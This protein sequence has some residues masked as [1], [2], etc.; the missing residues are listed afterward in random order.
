M[1]LPKDH[2]FSFTDTWDMS[3]SDKG[4]EGKRREYRA[5]RPL[6]EREI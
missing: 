3:D 5:R 1:D 4:K 2:F 6:E